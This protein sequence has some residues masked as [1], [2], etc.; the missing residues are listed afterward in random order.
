MVSMKTVSEILSIIGRNDL[1]NELGVGLT[2][3][4]A[5]SV[6]NKFPS[7]WYPIVM[8]MSARH[9]VTVSRDAFNWRKRVKAETKQGAA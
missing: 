5:A 9:G 4:S 1:A 6:S 8:E 7:A 3:I 2:A